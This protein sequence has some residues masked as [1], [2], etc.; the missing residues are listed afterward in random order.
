MQEEFLRPT[1]P[2]LYGL[3]DEVLCLAG[4][5]KPATSLLVHLGS[6]SDSIHRQEHHLPG[7]DDPEQRLGTGG[8]EK[9]KKS[10]NEEQENKGGKTGDV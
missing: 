8:G 3:S 9:E 4:R 1:N 7:L 6:R 5:A 2:D 10:R